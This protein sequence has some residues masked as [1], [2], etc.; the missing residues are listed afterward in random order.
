M[1]SIFLLSLVEDVIIYDL[2]VPMTAVC[3]ILN[4]SFSVFCGSGLLL[5]DMNADVQLA[6]PVRLSI[7]IISKLLVLNLVLVFLDMILL[8]PMI[9]LFGITTGAGIFF[10]LIMAGKNFVFSKKT[11][12]FGEVGGRGF[13]PTL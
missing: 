5:S 13:N 2:I 11:S 1:G 10:Y 4:I 3:L 9:V 12:H 7:L 6:L 8:L